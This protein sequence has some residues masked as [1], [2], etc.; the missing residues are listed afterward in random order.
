MPHLTSRSA[1]KHDIHNGSEQDS[2]PWQPWT[3]HWDMR[4]G[5]RG[6]KAKDKQGVT[7]QSHNY[8]VASLNYPEPRC[9]AR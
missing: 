3:V 1:H 4:K 8:L 5:Q 6:A 2:L 9:T 7:S